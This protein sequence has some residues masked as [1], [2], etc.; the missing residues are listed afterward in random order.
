[1]VITTLQAISERAKLL[2]TSQYLFSTFTKNYTVQFMVAITLGFLF[3]NKRE[4]FFTTSVV[5][6]PLISRHSHTVVVSIL[7]IRLTGGP[8]SV[9][10]VST[11][12]P[13]K[14]SF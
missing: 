1:M 9:S 12:W 8:L 14:S 11:A 13:M 6:G 2:Q 4:D 10:H 5:P 7:V 3:A